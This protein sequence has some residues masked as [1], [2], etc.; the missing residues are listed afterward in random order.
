VFEGILGFDLLS[1][2][3]ILSSELIGIGDHL[4]NLFL[5]EATLII[6][7]SD[8]LSLAGSFVASGDVEDTIGIDIK[9]NLDLWSTTGCWRD[10]FKVKFSEQMVILG[11][12]SF[13]FEDLDEDTRLIVHGCGESLLLLSR[14]LSISWD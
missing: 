13:T 14:D 4:L 5:G 7:N 10:S 9:S 6:S 8:L 12:L 1:D 2:D 11:H 3:I